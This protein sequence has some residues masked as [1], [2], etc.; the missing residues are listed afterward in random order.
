MS[1]KYY[2]YNPIP[3]LEMKIKPKSEIIAKFLCGVDFNDS[4]IYQD[5]IQSKY[6]KETKR[7]IFTRTMMF[8]NDIENTYT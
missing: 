4:L 6:P 2:E 3:Y 1:T 7:D 8:H 5:E